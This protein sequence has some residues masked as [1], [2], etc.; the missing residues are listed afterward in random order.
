MFGDEFSIVLKLAALWPGVTKTTNRFGHSGTISSRISALALSDDNDL[1]VWTDKP[2]SSATDSAVG[3]PWPLEGVK[4]KSERLKL[5]R[6]RL[7][8]GDDRLFR[9]VLSYHRPGSNN[10]P[11]GQSTLPS[12]RF[13]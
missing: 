9:H 7:A 11:Q 10:S 4:T 2:S 5:E 8:F 3:R 6:I 13:G 12:T 1:T